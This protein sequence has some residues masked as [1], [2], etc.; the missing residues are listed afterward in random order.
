MRSRSAILTAA[1]LFV[2]ASSPAQAVTGNVT[3]NGSVLGVCLLTISLPGTMTADATYTTLSSKN[4]GG[5]AGTALIVTTGS[6]FGITTST[7]TSFNTA[8]STGN[9]NVIFL[10]EY[11]LSGAT[12]VS[13]VLGAT[14]TLLGLGTT[15]VD[16]DLTATKTLN[17]FETG[18][19]SAAVTVTCD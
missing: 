9:D 13:N 15:S 18:N 6:G 3:F 17:A 10:S 2:A 4:A 14:A 11:S 19:Y 7:P 16:V 1:A 5:S 12:I 8:P